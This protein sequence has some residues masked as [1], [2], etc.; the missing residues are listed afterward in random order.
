MPVRKVSSRTG[1]R[2][3]ADV[4]AGPLRTALVLQGGA[5]LGA[6]EAGVLKALLEPPGRRF[7][8]VTGCSI[9][10][11][12]A[13]ILVGSRGDPCE[14]LDDL[15][16]RL[17]M[18]TNP[19]VP[20]MFANTIPTPGPGNLYRVNPMYYAAP[21]LATY[22]YESEPLEKAI[23]EWVDFGRVRRSPA[24]LV[25]V[26][27]D[28]K[29]GQA[30][31]ILESPQDDRTSHRGQ[32]QPASGVSGRAH[33]RGRLLGRRTDLQYAATSGTECHRATQ[34]E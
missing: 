20:G 24:E 6:Y 23:D 28:V 21:P 13:A 10:A 4:A 26:A 22:M 14:S 2:R 29:T 31:G 30:R 34:R 1:S 8:I 3:S 25:V 33:R 15:W 19:F 11:I 9:G 7:D 18:P 5:A 12:M 27:V 16:Q 17:A 32:R